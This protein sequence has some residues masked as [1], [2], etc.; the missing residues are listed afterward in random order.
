MPSNRLSLNPSKTQ[1]V[2]LGTRQ[3]LLKLD[4]AL[5]VAQF[6]QFIFLTPVHDLGVTLSQ[7][8]SLIYPDLAYSIYAP[9][10]QPDAL[11]P[12]VYIYV[13]MVHALV[14]SRG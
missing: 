5:L 6:S 13:Y 9:Y 1:L 11:L 14:C 3:Q 12:C 10:V 7:R 4:F 2:G 8:T